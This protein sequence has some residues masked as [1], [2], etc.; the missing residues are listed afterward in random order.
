[1]FTATRSTGHRKPLT[2]QVA[3]RIGLL[4]MLG[5]LLACGFPSL[6]ATTEAIEPQPEEV[7]EPEATTPA[8]P[9][10]RPAEAET[11]TWTASPTATATAFAPRFTATVN[12]NCRG[13]P[14][15]VY[16]IV[17]NLPSGT[18]VAITGKDVTGTWWYVAHE[19]FCWVSSTTGVA[20]GDLASL[21]VIP[22]PPTPSATYTPTPTR[23]ATPGVII[24]PRI[25]TIVIPRLAVVSGASVSASPTSYEGPCPFTVTWHGAITA[26]GALTATYVWEIG[27]LD[28]TWTPVTSTSLTFSGAGT[29]NTV[30][31]GIRASFSQL[32]KF[33]LHVTAPNS[34]YSNEVSVTIQCVP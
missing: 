20:G 6:E 1:M 13:G 9:E 2:R 23:T 11:P 27:Y 29:M 26:T 7:E 15:T 19:V 32:G 21:P 25:G 17:G 34:L 3:L 16:G 10:A 14:G 12:A 4:G 18:T 8:P 33:R 22:S 28:G 30:D 31:Q 5:P 24:N